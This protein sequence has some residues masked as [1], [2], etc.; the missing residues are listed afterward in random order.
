M[1]AQVQKRPRMYLPRD[2]YFTIDA[3]VEGCDQG[4]AQSLLLGFREWL[5]TKT[6]CG[7]NL[8]WWAL[9]RDLARPDQP[10]LVSDMTAEHDSAAVATL[11]VLL[12]EFLAL[13]AEPDGL[14]RIY[15]AHQAWTASRRRV[16][17]IGSGKAACPMG[18]APTPKRPL[19]DGP[20]TGQ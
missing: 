1:F 2:D 6:G 7:D 20:S 3:F 11:F 10:E 18:E 4:N 15:A 19:S 16:G 14:N 9:V 17:C 8:V 12:D 13:R 5:V